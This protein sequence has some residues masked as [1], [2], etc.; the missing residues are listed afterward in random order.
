[1]K[2]FF[3]LLLI[4]MVFLGLGCEW[5]QFGLELEEDCKDE[6]EIIIVDYLQANNFMEDV[7]WYEFGVYYIIEEEGEGVLFL[8]VSLQILVCYKGMLLDGMVFD[9]I[10]EEDVVLLN[11]LRMIDGWCFVILFIKRGGKIKFFVFFNLVYGINDGN[12]G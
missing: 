2:K 12:R 4:G 5:Q 8:I 7:V 3:F 9:E 6:D 1:M 11:L 10:E